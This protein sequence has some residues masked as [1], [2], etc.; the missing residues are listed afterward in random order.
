MTNFVS[1]MQKTKE[2]LIT[3]IERVLDIMRPGIQMHAGGV[4][5]VDVDIM[6]GK[7][8]IRM[9]G[10]CVGCPMSDM[11]LK[12]GIEETLREMVP[13]VTEVVAA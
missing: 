8:T 5:L 13:E 9:Q 10:A 12:M 2:E 3:E 1:I 6:T 4:E 11:T 7:V